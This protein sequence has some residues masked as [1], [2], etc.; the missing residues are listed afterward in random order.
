MMR[1]TLLILVLATV[2]FGQQIYLNNAPITFEMQG[3]TSYMPD[4]GGALVPGYKLKMGFNQFSW[5]GT[6][7]LIKAY[8]S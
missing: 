3:S 4:T 6:N 2:S 7:I 1:E 8:S 5:L